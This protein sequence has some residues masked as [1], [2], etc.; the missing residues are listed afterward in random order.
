MWIADDEYIL[1]CG[2][3]EQNHMVTLNVIRER[4]T[5]DESRAVH[6]M[7]SIGLQ[8]DDFASL[9]S[10]VKAAFLYVFKRRRFWHYGGAF[11]PGNF[12]E[13]IADLEGAAQFILRACADMRKNLGPASIPTEGTT[14]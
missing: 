5:D 14:P 13:S 1:R 7:L 3:G 6:H 12:D 8:P 11:F 2:C 4:I 9:W 10:R